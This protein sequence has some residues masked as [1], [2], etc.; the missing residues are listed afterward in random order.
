MTPRKIVILGATLALLFGASQARAGGKG[1]RGG[2]GGKG[3][4]GSVVAIVTNHGTFQ[5]QLFR[6]KAPNTTANFL[7]YVSSGFYKGTTFHRVISNFMIQGG[8][9]TKNMIRKA[10]RAAIRNEATNGLS[11]KRYTV[12]MARTGSPHSATAQFFVNVK[13]NTFLDHKAPRGR[14]WGYC[15]FAKVI[16]GKTVVEKIRNVS[17]GRVG[18]RP[19]VPL[20]PVVIKRVYVIK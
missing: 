18:G 3:K 10:T 1:G 15:V 16:S 6:K 2:K 14:L 5:I 7:K 8:G 9:L 12:A 20:R 13:D 19:N 11:N 4:K 17:T